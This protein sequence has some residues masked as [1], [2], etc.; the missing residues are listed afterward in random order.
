MKAVVFSV[1]ALKDLND[2]F[3]FQ[4]A[5]NPRFAVDLTDRLR[6]A[7]RSLSINPDR[8][9]AA[10]TSRRQVRRLVAAGYVIVYSS[11]DVV[12][13]LRIVHGSRNI[14]AILADL[15]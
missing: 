14:A 3:E 12:R 13:V 4:V 11:E 8:G 15:P 10:R 1:A 9:A 6:A 2:I 7:A 5:L